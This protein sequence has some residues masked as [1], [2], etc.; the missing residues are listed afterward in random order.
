MSHDTKP[1]QAKPCEPKS[2]SQSTKK[3]S[4]PDQFP[5]PMLQLWEGE[6]R[7]GELPFSEWPQGQQAAGKRRPKM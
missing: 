3:S 7:R 6:H 1:R 5:S 4:K 2:S